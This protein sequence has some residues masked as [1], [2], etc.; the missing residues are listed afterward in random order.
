MGKGSMFL[1]ATLSI[2][3]GQVAWGILTG[4][5]PGETVLRWYFMTL[6]I[7]LGLLLAYLQENGTLR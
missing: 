3:V 1:K 2:L 6:G 4:L 7:G 5:A